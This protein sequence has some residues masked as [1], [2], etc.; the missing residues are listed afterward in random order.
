MTLY[1]Y[2]VEQVDKKNLTL[3]QFLHEANLTYNTIYNL[4]KRKPSMTTYQK[5][6]KVLDVDVSELR[7]YSIN[8]DE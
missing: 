1:E 7:S 2:I 5:I 8:H 3:G 4:R 6:A